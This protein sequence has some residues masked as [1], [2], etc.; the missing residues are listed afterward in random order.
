MIAKEMDITDIYLQ[1]EVA[2]YAYYNSDILPRSQYL[3]EI[4]PPTYDPLDSLILVAVQESIRVHAW[5]NALLVWSLKDPPDSSRHLFYQRPEWFIKDATGTSMR[6]YTYEHWIESGLE[7][8]YLDAANPEVQNHIATICKEIVAQYPVT[9]IH[10]DFI[11]YPGTLWGLSESDTA[12]MFAGP[13]GYTMR[14][15]NLVRYPQMSFVHR[16]LAYHNWKQYINKEQNIAEI[17]DKT[18]KSITGHAK[19]PLCILTA[20]VFA[21]P[22]MAQY[23]FAQ[24]W[25]A[26]TMIDYPV[27]MSYYETLPP[28]L[29]AVE[30]ALNTVPHAV[31]GIGLL[32]ENIDPIAYM[33]SKSVEAKHGKGICY[34]DF[35]NLDTLTDRTVL[36]GKGMTFHMTSEHLDSTPGSIFGVFADPAPRVSDI[37]VIESISTEFP[38]FLL[39]LSLEPDQDL[40][41][42]N[43]TYEQ[44]VA[45]VRKDVA[46]FHFLD[47]KIFPLPDTLIEPPS[48]TVQYEFYPWDGEDTLR[49][50]SK[51]SKSTIYD[52]E[53]TVYPDALD[54]FTRV[55]FEM[56]IGQKSVFKTGAGVY[57]LRITAETKGGKRSSR[58]RIDGNVLPLYGSWTI[59]QRIGQ[60][61]NQ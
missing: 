1:A 24:C 26:W 39:S 46:A 34:F 16:W 57:A 22:S 61:L 43:L 42:L 3:A 30:Y 32:W 23:R 18:K 31:F 59:M 40:D 9:G 33:Q 51:A 37:A 55:V 28:F 10:L 38:D 47:T 17:L 13:D 54:P 52:S 48:R 14:W 20:A 27:I 12:F 60:I 53:K 50:L 45:Y 44:F 6:D 21:N 19:N 29:A 4:S 49:I 8:L 5:V 11:R 56:K 25:H 2:G 15:M 58:D 35:T 36:K 7:G 41:R